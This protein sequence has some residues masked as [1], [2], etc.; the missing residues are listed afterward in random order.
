MVDTFQAGRITGITSNEFNALGTVHIT[1]SRLPTKFQVVLTPCSFDGGGLLG[2]DYLKREKAE[3]SFGLSTMVTRTD[4][5]KPTHFLEVKDVGKPAEQYHTSR[6]R[7][8][9]VKTRSRQSIGIDVISPEIKER[10]LPKCNPVDGIYIGEAAVSVDNGA[11]H[12]LAINTLDWDAEVEIPP[13]EILPFQ[14]HN[15][16]EEYD[17]SFS[18]CQVTEP[19]KSNRTEALISKLRL[20]HSNQEETKHVSDLIYEFPNSFHLTNDSLPCAQVYKHQIPTVDNIPIN[21]RQYRFPPIYKTEIERQIH[22][23]LL[24]L[25]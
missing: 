22:I 19:I 20:E 13:Q 8:F 10:F 5:I 25:K 6:N 1:L 21:T 16:P 4:P 14:Y 2:K 11:C 18:D 24:C 12:V 23:K 7:V 15:F 3:I 17:D 9:L